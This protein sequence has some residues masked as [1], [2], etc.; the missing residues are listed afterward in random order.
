MGVEGIYYFPM[1]KDQSSTWLEIDLGAIKHNIRELHQITRTQVMPIIKANAYGHGL[2]G[3][4]RAIEESGATWCGVARLEEAVKLRKEGIRIN[5]L[6]L[7]YTDY[8]RVGEAVAN[9][10]SLTLHNPEMA[11]QFSEQ[12]RANGSHLRVHVKFD[13]GM[14]RLGLFPKDGIEFVRWLNLQK[15]IN[16]EGIF[17]HFACAD[18]PEND[19]TSNQIKKFNHLIDGLKECGIRPKYVHA[20]NSAG[21]LYFPESRYDLIRPGIAIFGLHP[22]QKAPL[23]DTFKPAL[24]WKSRLISIKDL[25]PGHGVSY[26][27]RYITTKNEHIGVIPVG[28]ADGYR[29]IANNYV[30]VHG[31]RVPV[32]GNVCMDQC[33]LQMDNVPEAKIKDEVILIGSQGDEEITAEDLAESWGTINY[34]VICGLARRLPRFYSQ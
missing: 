1:E 8:L 11:Q 16:V 20:A 26:G 4:A 32:I 21:A 3:V 29:R 12:S 5:I 2:I 33:M 24:S 10:V 28:Y 14:G 9:Q 17:T 25:P 31:K 15:G 18:E 22:S 19:T 30:L 6:V 27:F 13:T 7:G 34:E 23:P